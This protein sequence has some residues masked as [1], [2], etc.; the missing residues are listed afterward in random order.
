MTRALLLLTYANCCCRRLQMLQHCPQKFAIKF[1]C[2]DQSSKAVSSSD[3][4]VS[5]AS[6]VMLPAQ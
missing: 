2:Y 5:Y 4:S 6:A 3:S 1:N